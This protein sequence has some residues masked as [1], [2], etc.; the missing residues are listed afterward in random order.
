MTTDA[1]L[2]TFDLKILQAMSTDARMTVTELSQKVGLS[3]TPCHIRLKRLETEGYIL[4]YTALVDLVKLG[5]EHIAFVEVKLSD[6]RAKALNEFNKAVLG[7][8]EIEQCHMI[9]GGFDYLLKVRTKNI[10]DYRRLLGETL[11]T[12]PH[13]AQTSTYV[14][15]E[16][17]KETAVLSGIGEHP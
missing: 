6:T 11:S 15:M 5:L 8:S 2:D 4:G 16:S 9:A 1:E 13:V 10:S 14:S 3:K 12:L 17:V 7:L